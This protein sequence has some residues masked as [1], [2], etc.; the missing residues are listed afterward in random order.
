[1]PHF[2]FQRPRQPLPPFPQ[3]VKTLCR[4]TKEGFLSGWYFQG[5]ENSRNRL[6]HLT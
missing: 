1:M 4:R 2:R 6:W 3:M 5:D